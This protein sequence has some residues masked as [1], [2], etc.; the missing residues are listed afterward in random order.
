MFPPLSPVLALTATATSATKATVIESLSLRPDTFKV[1]VSANRAN[2]FLHKMKVSRAVHEAFGWLID[3]IKER[4]PNTPRTIIYCKQQKECGR[5]VHHFKLELGGNTYYPLHCVPSSANM[6]IGMYHHSTLTKHQERVLDSLFHE[7]GV[8]W[9]VFSSTELGMG[10]NNKDIRMVV[11]YGPPMHMDDFFQEIGRAGHDL[12]PAKA[13]LIYHGGHLRKCDKVV[14]KY[15]KSE[16]TCLRQIILSEFDE[17]ENDLVYSHNCCNICH[18]KCQYGVTEC[19]V[20]LLGLAD[21][22]RHTKGAT[23]CKSGKVDCN[24]KQLLQELFQDLR[25]ELAAQGSSYFLPF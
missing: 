14:K 17:T 6:I 25:D 2:I 4:G 22:Q 7:A 8:C 3:M 10:V 18:Q 12:Q 21:K 24:Q 23:S 16:D 19:A 1:Y 9:V 5:L 11:H 20:P 15:A 13:V